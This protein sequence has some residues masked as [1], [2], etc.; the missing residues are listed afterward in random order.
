MRPTRARPASVAISYI[1]IIATETGFPVYRAAGRRAPMS[2]RQTTSADV[3]CW[4]V[5]RCRPADP[6][7]HG[8]GASLEGRVRVLLRWQAG[9]C[10][11]CRPVVTTGRLAGSHAR[12]AFERE[13]L[14]VVPFRA[15]SLTR[16]IPHFNLNTQYYEENLLSSA[17]RS[18][19]GAIV[20]RSL[21]GRCSLSDCRQKDP[22]SSQPASVPRRS[23]P[24]CDC[25]RNARRTG[26]R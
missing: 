10:L 16:R 14:S 17:H 19:H 18:I 6:G 20:T 13:D 11:V 24:A 23:L 26:L 7:E 12:L 5:A 15:K 4:S 1:R 2:T 21:G 22:G 9:E 25:E 8:G 3:P